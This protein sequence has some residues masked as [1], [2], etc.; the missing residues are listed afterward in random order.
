MSRGT[1][2]WWSLVETTLG[3]KSTEARLAGFP[4]LFMDLKQPEKQLICELVVLDRPVQT[5]TP[6]AVSRYPLSVYT[7]SEQVCLLDGR[8]LA[9]RVVLV[10]RNAA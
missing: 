2:P 1:S 9:M 5:K 10:W 6:P 4:A 7:V 3:V 8:M